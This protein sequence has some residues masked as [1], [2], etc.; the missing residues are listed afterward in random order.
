MVGHS[1]LWVCTW[2]SAPA[3]SFVDGCVEVVDMTPLSTP[4]VWDLISDLTYGTGLAGHVAE[5]ASLAAAAAGN[6]GAIIELVRGIAEDRPGPLELP[7]RS[8]ARIAAHLR[9]TCPDTRDVVAVAA[10]LGRPLATSEAARVLQLSIFHAAR[11]VDEAITCGLL[12]MD[13]G[14]LVSLPHEQVRAVVLSA[15]APAVTSAVDGALVAYGLSTAQPDRVPVLPEP[16]GVLPAE[17]P[18]CSLLTEQQLRI[19]DL[20]ADGL[21]NRM[22]ARRLHL[23]EYTIKYH[24]REIFKKLGISSRVQLAMRRPS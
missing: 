6:P 4:A 22:I 11:A 13:S 10:K 16:E 18:D 3:D 21:T 1:L 9:R 7:R 14:G 12:V 23:S 5:I 15:I 17:P 8:R 24:L 2:R 20:V 19:A